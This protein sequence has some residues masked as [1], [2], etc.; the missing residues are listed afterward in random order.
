MFSRGLQ[1][2]RVSVAILFV[3]IALAAMSPG[4]RAHSDSDHDDAADLGFFD[5]DHLP[6]GALTALPTPLDGWAKLEC[7]SAGQKLV[8]K[9]PWRWRFPGSWLNRPDLP[10]WA[11]AASFT[12]PGPKHFVKMEIVE[13]DTQSTDAAHDKLMRESATYRFH[14]ETR[15]LAMHRMT[16]L[17]SLGHTM[18]VYFPTVS[19][20]LRWAIL[21]VPDCRPEYAF[22]IE[23]APR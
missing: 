11:P 1:R 9:L 20:D 6:A 14:V 10:A 3:P 19:D 23:R 22:L 4:V 18:D 21:C 16:V 5:C 7:T 8:A 17:N 12:L 15:P 2:W 13:L